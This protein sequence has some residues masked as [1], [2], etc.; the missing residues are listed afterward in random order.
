MTSRL[1]RMMIVLL[2]SGCVTAEP[3]PQTQET[4]APL[5]AVAEKQDGIPFQSLE[6]YQNRGEEL[7]P[8]ANKVINSENKIL[9][10]DDIRLF[11]V[12]MKTLGFDPGLTDGVMGPKTEKALLRFQS[13]CAALS[14]LWGG[15]GME[16]M[17]KA[18][19]APE[20]KLSATANQ[21]SDD[22]DDIRRLQ[23][24]M[25]AAGLDPGPVDGIMGPKTKSLF[26]A[27]QSGCSLLKMFPAISQQEL[28]MP[29]K[30]RPVSSNP[31]KSPEPVDSSTSAVPATVNK[32]TSPQSVS[33]K[34]WL[35]PM[36]SN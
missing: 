12:R 36:T 24:R 29:E 35:V 28:K 31:K 6:S 8:L 1:F 7:E 22:K 23:A 4:Q 14:D 16:P 9:G 10:R 27:A 3:E 5:P 15:A 30:Q 21:I 13:T 20:T 17:R 11:Q 18:A 2:I 25:K 33:R 32:K 26:F 34:P 19:D